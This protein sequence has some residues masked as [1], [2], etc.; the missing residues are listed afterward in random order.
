VDS[1]P[2]GA[3]RG[4]GLEN[5]EFATQMTP[6]PRDSGDMS[7]ET[8]FSIGYSSEQTDLS[9]F[10]GF[11]IPFWIDDDEYASLAAHWDAT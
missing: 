7:L 4:P 8:M 6:Y 3:S 10:E 9:L 5:T 2:K 1:D 11:D